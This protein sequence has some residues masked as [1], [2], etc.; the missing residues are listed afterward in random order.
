[1]TRQALAGWEAA[2]GD[3]AL[4]TLEKWARAL[5]LDITLTP[6]QRTPTLTD[7]SGS[8]V[9]LRT[10]SC[11]ITVVGPNRP[12]VLAALA[13]DC[14]GMSVRSIGGLIG[15][16]YDDLELASLMSDLE[17]RKASPAVIV[18][19]L[20]GDESRYEMVVELLGRAR[21]NGVVAMI[22]ADRLE[23]VP[24]IILQNAALTLCCDG[25]ETLSDLD[26]NRWY[27]TNH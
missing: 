26:G 13:A 11:H 1:V 27:L 20:T 14:G 3:V 9:S 16:P 8:P 12:H 6:T 10:L 19:E 25:S 5:D 18:T 2:D 17:A 4:S 22:G 24:A 21:A 15:D 23:D 7:S